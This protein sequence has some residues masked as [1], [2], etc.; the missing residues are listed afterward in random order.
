MEE[1]I[2]RRGVPF[3]AEVAS[4]VSRMPAVDEYRESL[5]RLQSVWDSLSMMG[6]M[7]GA[8]PDIGDT[9]SAFQSLTE[10][11]LDNLARR[12]LLNVTRRMRGH[13]QV[14]ID[15]LVRNLFERTADVGFLSTDAVLRRYV[16]HAV[17]DGGATALPAER[18]ALEARFRAYVA[19]YSVYDDI[20]ALSTQGRVLAR[21]ARDA[22]L[23]QAVAPGQQPWMRQALDGAP[24]AE[25]HGPSALMGGREALLYAAAIRGE[26]GEPMGV[27]ALSFRFDDEMAGIFRKLLPQ[28]DSTVLALVKPS[29]EVLAS[30]DPW[31]VPRGAPLPAASGAS[32]QRVRFCGRDYL[33]AIT[34][35]TGYEG[36]AGPG[37]SA[38]AM[39]PVDMA[40]EI[41]GDR[42]DAAE[43][44]ALVQS[45]DSKDLFDEE[46]RAIPEQA[47]RI[48]GDLS[49]LLWNGKLR[50]LSHGGSVAFG[51][52]LLR[53]IGG[54]GE[55]IR[56]VFEQASQKLL[57]EALNAVFDEAADH[58]ALAIDIMDRN[59]YE[60]A[61]DCR[62]WALDGT[63]K[64]ALSRPGGLDEGGRAEATQV[65][66]HINGLY[67]VYSLLVL[68]DADRR[69]VAVS[70]PG[71]ADA[72][73]G[74][75]LDDAWAHEV[76][77]LQDPERYVMSPHAP[78][79]LYD[80]RATYVYAAPVLGDGPG[81][82]QA[83]GG[84]AIVFDGERQFAAML[85]DSLAGS[86][87]GGE[88]KNTGLL[89]TRGGRVVASTAV[90]WP[91]GQPGP[92]LPK[93]Q[94]LQAGQ[95]L[96]T[97]IEIDGVAFCAGVCMSS[98]YREY[99]HAAPSGGEHVAAVMLTRLGEKLRAEAGPPP[100]FEA[101][102]APA[103]GGDG[104]LEIAGFLSDG[105]WLGMPSR[106]V[107]EALSQARIAPLPNAPAHL[108][109][110]LPYG[111]AL[112]PVVD[113]AALR[114]GPG[115]R[116]A[117]DSPVI[118]VQA[119]DGRRYALKVQALGPVFDAA[120][121]DIQPAAQ[122]AWGGS[123]ERLVKG[124]G[125]MLTLLDADALLVSA[126]LAGAPAAPPLPMP[127][128]QAAATAVAPAITA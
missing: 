53:E 73:V 92:A 75:P 86:A 84:V 59:L 52:T 103:G 54:T 91:V 122:T 63:L 89:V 102:A 33:S 13:A 108:P 66:Q 117:E 22:D 5:L 6:Q 46:L 31:Q 60:R 23:P 65:L 39:V 116:E 67:T 15:I 77:A 76:L 34:P 96:T 126:G 62:W 12:L 43:S 93:L 106:S 74:R 109:G 11:L 4:L 124:R 25:F 47:R 128:S 35:A 78:H 127:L 123:G 44:Q 105:L 114:G 45:L 94:S 113:V 32:R 118:V 111:D 61:N 72:W 29:G 17:R 80:G 14:A 68:F 50:Q 38:R 64:R 1:K 87:G 16:A 49:R 107:V 19:K 27:L 36:Y 97:V 82:P 58:A 56:Q 121:G 55:L 119:G 40:F 24:Y 37:W 69:V 2:W 28:Q 3:S 26:R 48:Q 42:R 100:L 8:A 30:S 7:S 99:Q 104:A 98:G 10:T 115:A 120:A 41:E 71:S 70:K 18:E 83:V 112:L 51:S 88:G 85:R 9:R 110:L 81:A 20:V 125:Q 57:R 95:G 79:A 101:T 21:L 90:R